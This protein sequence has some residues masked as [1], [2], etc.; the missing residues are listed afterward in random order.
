MASQ[1][2]PGIL[3]QEVDKTLAVAQLQPPVGAIAGH[4]SWGPL[5]EVITVSSEDQLV[6]RFGKPGANS[7]DYFFTAANF[8]AYSNSLRV[9]R[10]A[11][12]TTAKAATQSQSSANLTGTY[13]V[14]TTSTTMVV[15]SANAL[16]V[17]HPG[18]V[19][20][21]ATNSTS[22][23]LVT[24]AS[25]T[26]NATAVLTANATADLTAVNA[27]SFGLYISNRDQYDASYSSGEASVGEWAARCVG[28]LGNSLRVELC[29]SSNAY[30]Q[31]N[32]ASSSITSSGVTITVSAN[33]APYVQ[34]GDLVTANGSPGETR[35]VTAVTNGTQFTINTA[36][37]TALSSSNWQRKWKYASLF[38]G[39]P[40][41]STWTTQRGGSTDELHVVVVDEDGL[42]SGV[43]NTVLEKYEFLSKAID[44]KSETGGN[45]YYRDVV[46]DRSSYV[47][48]LDHPAGTTNWGAAASGTTF[49]TPNLLSGGSL[50]GGVDGGSIVAGDVQRGYDK[51][52]DETVEIDTVLGGP[53]SAT[54]AA[55]IINN[56]VLNRKYTMGFFSPERSDV[57]NQ[58]GNEVANIL[59]YRDALPSTSYAVLDSGWKYQYDKYNDVYRYVPLNADVAGCLV[60]TAQQAETWFSPAGFTRGQIKNS[61]KL[62]WNPRQIDRDDLYV[63]GVNPVV[64][65]SGQGTVLYGDK[66]LLSKP[67]AFDRI[68]VR[69]L[70][71]VL[72]KTIETAAQQLLFEQNDEFTRNQF[73]NLVEPF[74]RQVKGRRGISDFL[75]VCDE[76]NNPADAVQRNEFRAD[77]YVKP[78]RSINF[79]QLNVVAVRA[80]VAFNE[81]VTNLQ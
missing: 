14:N 39:A 16:A 19:V 69:R 62:A 63:K 45:L 74:L 67:T 75:V 64:T 54:T 23:S 66:T 4:F 26:D 47:W 60:R 73:I 17:L 76:T 41:T 32:V 34:V 43:A 46:N 77:V 57:V 11:N 18:M 1:V 51:F 3:V 79:I 48:W 15:A 78:I 31:A 40:G 6:T 37:S 59:E 24:V 30:S 70:F 28:V 61:V 8:L 50:N 10:V 33:V 55:Y 21:V 27:A 36:F 80:D 38:G 2:S 56:I 42:F 53:A 5:E 22:F 49:S 52:K 68:N 44:A 12:T 65:F 13:T 7:A 29:A 81:V 9:V 35:Q 25:V 72:E 71:I 58:A 20:N